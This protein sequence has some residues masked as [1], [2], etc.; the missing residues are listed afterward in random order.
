MS[1][2]VAENERGRI[3]VFALSMGREEA[4]GLQVG[5][6][7]DAQEAADAAARQCAALGVA[8]IDTDHTEVFP[9]SDL[10]DLGLA[11][12]LAEGGGARDEDIAANRA[13]LAGLDGWVML[14][15]SQA[16]DG[17]SETLKP[18]PELTL[19]ATLSQPG[20]DWSEGQRL[21]SKAATEAPS[22]PAKRPSDAAMSGRVA[23]VTLLVLFALTA[24]MVWISG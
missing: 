7:T 21:T 19:I 12:Y 22:A 23:T 15:Y 13:R 1:L 24:V 2:E 3:R 10:G 9:I 14:V 18:S 6:D 16:F 4:L 8:Q 17:R 11:G 20:T 5:P